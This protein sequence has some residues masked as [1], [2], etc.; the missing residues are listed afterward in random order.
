MVRK[1]SARFWRLAALGAVG[2]PLVWNCW[3]GW[4]YGLEIYPAENVR[5]ERVAIVFGARIYAD[6][7]LSS[8]LRDRVETAVQLYE[9]GKVNKLLLSGDNRFVDYDEPGRM[10]DYA[11]ARGVPEEDLQPDYGG[12]RTYD[13]CYRAREIFG[14]ESA[15][16]VSQAF[17]LPRALF[18]CRHIGID[19]VGVAADLQPYSRRSLAWSRLREMPALT[20]ALVDVIKRSPPPVLGERIPI[21]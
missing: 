16:L 7:R 5:K 12:R 18:I 3:V 10:M 17:H 8:M 4:R 9:A 2:L 1:R 13:T 15:V 11:I 19:A 14:L 21:N 20:A 6:G